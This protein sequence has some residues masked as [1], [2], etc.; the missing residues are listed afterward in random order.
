[1]NLTGYVMT[2]HH[3]H[4]RDV[5]PVISAHIVGMYGLVLVV[6]DLIERIGRRESL[7][8]GLLIMG[9]STLSLAWVAS[10]VATGVA[11]F[12]LGLGWSLSYV[13]ATTSLVDLA[14]PRGAR[15]SSSASATCS[16]GSAP[17][18]SR[19]SAGPPT[20]RRGS[21]RSRSAGGARDAA[22]ALAR[23]RPE[24]PPGIR[25]RRARAPTRR[26]LC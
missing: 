5:F 17:P 20:A 22:G 25:A 14:A 18:P 8:A 7:V 16:R 21:S 6:G 12:G 11:L 24:V 13:A 10:V 2:G 3:H 1:M 26:S 9:A 15:H 4:Q 23:G 19:C